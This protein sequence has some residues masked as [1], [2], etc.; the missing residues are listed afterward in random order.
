MPLAEAKWV[1]DDWVCL[2]VEPGAVEGLGTPFD[3]VAPGSK[4]EVETPIGS[5]ALES[6]VEVETPVD[7]GALEGMSEAPYH[8]TLSWEP[9]AAATAV[10]INSMV[11]RVAF[12]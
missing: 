6:K 7:G 9:V 1:E 4:V 10:D 3:S 5:V 2:V 8:N 11:S 12:W